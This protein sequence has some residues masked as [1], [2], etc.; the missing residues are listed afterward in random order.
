MILYIFIVLFYYF[1]SQRAFK[2]S[3]FSFVV[4]CTILNPGIAIRFAP[5]SISVDLILT[6][7]FFTK[8]LSNNKYRSSEP[9]FFKRP[10]VLLSLSY[11]ISGLLA[12]S[13][14][15]FSG[16]TTTLNFVITKAIK[17]YMLWNLITGKE[18]I[19][20]IV[21]H[22]MIVFSLIFVYG[23][24]EY[25]TQSNPIMTF[26][27]SMIPEQY[28]ESKL[29]VSDM[30][31][32][33]G[34]RTRLQSLLSIHIEYGVSAILFLFFVL[35]ISKYKFTHISDVKKWGYVVA[36]FLCL[37][38]S[39]SKTPLVVL[40]IFILPFLKG[41]R[42]VAFCVV[43]ITLL[44]FFHSQI[45]EYVYANLIDPDAFDIN[46][47]D[48]SKGSSLY[49][50]VIQLQVSI[51]AFLQAP[52]FGN[53]LRYASAVL[54][55]KDPL[56][57]GAESVWFKLLIEQGLFGLIAYCYMIY[58]FIKT[59]FTRTDSRSFLLFYTLGFFTICSITNLD[60]L[61]YFV[62]YIIIYKT[63]LLACDYPK[64]LSSEK[65]NQ[66]S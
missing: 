25:L 57:F 11:L 4:L 39:N 27:Y 61:L 28:A 35:K 13:F 20:R 52:L 60:Y 12:I 56:I 55:N 1:W 8:F 32:L 37:Y 36:S 31:G 6:L 16:I 3:F 66:I 41:R 22:Y 17:V 34:G 65:K 26:E 53:G 5:P 42:V 47:T 51:N 30:D 15:S 19:I 29:F 59:S 9:F 63:S 14:V 58:S 24:F 7:Y 46:N 10:F 48:M 21:R 2:N 40:P 50:R 44:L 23:V 49:M 45:A 33:R 62:F 54:A 64:E 18:D 38:F 43:S